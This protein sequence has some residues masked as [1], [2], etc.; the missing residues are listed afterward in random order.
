MSMTHGMVKIKRNR[1]SA[2]AVSLV[3]MVLISLGLL[4]MAQTVLAHQRL[5]KRRHELRKA[6]YAAEAGV[7]LV[8]HWGN[9]PGQ[10]TKNSDLFEGSGYEFP[11]LEAVIA[12]GEYHITESELKE[13]VTVHSQQYLR[14]PPR[15]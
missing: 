14:M 4:W 1:G 11:K 8:Q 3:L 6:Y 2:L 5:N 12:D 13:M 9:F 10:F 15:I 7:A